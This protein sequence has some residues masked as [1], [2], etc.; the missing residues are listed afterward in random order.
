M[1]RWAIILIGLALVG[2]AL[3]VFDRAIF[4]ALLIDGVR[5]KD[6]HQIL[7]Q[8]GDVR[9]WLV[10]SLLIY[11]MDRSSLSTLRPQQP[12]HHRAGLLLLS[13]FC[14]GLASEALKLVFRRLRPLE[15]DAVYAFRPFTEG[16]FSSSGLSFP[17]GH[18]AVAFGAC[19]MIGLMYRPI[20]WP[21]MLL[22]FGCG[23]SRINAGAHYPSD[24][25]AAGVVASAIALILFKLSEGMH[26]PRTDADQ[27]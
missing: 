16:T 7:R 25:W 20:L 17:S 5:E 22:G 21:M 18:T 23:V 2:A 24:V 19:F 27:T 26:R 4:D 12:R 15:T 14:S 8:L 1:K 9:T 10:V 11:L 3:F 13:V 6:W